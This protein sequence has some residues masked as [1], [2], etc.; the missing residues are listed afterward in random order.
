MADEAT[1]ELRQQR[2]KEFMSMLPLTLEL[3]GLPKAAP[4]TLFND[5]QMEARIISIRNAYKL[6]RQMLKEIGENGV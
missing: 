4:N 2:M 3:A 5:G 1:P 6:A